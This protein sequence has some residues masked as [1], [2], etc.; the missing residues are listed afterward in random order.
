MKIVWSVSILLVCAA[1]AGAQ[2]PAPA[3]APPGTAAAL[4][5]AYPN[6]QYSWQQTDI[7]RRLVA[8]GD[9]SVIASVEPYLDTT[10]RRRRCNA[11]FVLA[12]LGDERGIQILIEELKDTSIEKRSLEGAP[13]AAGGPP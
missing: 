6:T 7:A 2:A 5:A 1:E 8:I 13:R 10:D 4:V 11:A 12:G 3:A 9:K